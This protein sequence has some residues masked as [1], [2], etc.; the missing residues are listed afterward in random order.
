MTLAEYLQQN[1]LRK[2]AF[3]AR[4]GITPSHFSRV[5]SGTSKPSKSLTIAIE[6]VTGGEITEADWS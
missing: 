2:D 5:L 3:A 1:G 6:H 4:I